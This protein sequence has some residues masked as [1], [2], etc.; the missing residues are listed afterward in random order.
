MHTEPSGSRTAPGGPEPTAEPPTPVGPIHLV[1]DEIA[2]AYPGRPVFAGVTV[3]VSDGA[4]LGVVGENGS[5]KSTLLGVLAGALRPAAGQVRRAGTLA[6]VEQELPVGPKQTVGDLIAASLRGLREVAARLDAAARAFDHDAGNLNELAAL[7]ARAE[8]VAAWDADRRVDVALSRLGACRDAARPL[9]ELSVGERYRVRLACRLAE[10][11]D[12]ILLDEPTNHLDAGGIDFLTTEL[13][14]WRGAVVVVTHD[15]QLLD[16]V[17]TAILDL[18]PGLDGR[19]V[20]YGQ[21]GYLAYRFAKN[22]AMHRWRARYRA[23][24][25]RA[26][27]LAAQLDASYEGLSD[28]WRPLRGSEK[29]RRATRARTHVKA[30]DRAIQRLEAAAVEVPVPPLELRFPDLPAMAPGWDPGRALVEVRNPRVG[31]ADRPWLDLP[32]TRIAVPASGRLLVTGPNGAG[33]STLL[34]ALAGTVALDRGTRSAVDGVRLGLLAQ[35]GSVGPGG[36]GGSP[37][38]DGR[39]QSPERAGPAE[40]PS[41]FDVYAREALDLL[42]AGGLDPDHLVPVATLG[43]LT[44]AD[45]DRPLA[46]LSAGQRRRFEI[47]RTL[48]AAPHLLMLDEPTNHLSIDLMD[49]LTLALRATAA[50]VVVATHDRRMRD[51]LQDWP[52][53]D[54][55]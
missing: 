31:P 36:D 43:L 46:E 26:V 55:G 25:K 14:T 42:A 48:L 10:R 23:E 15:R 4:R 53:L 22:Q 33:K 11:P 50:A 20:L 24:R 54:L 51:E 18:D 3:R 49:E 5:G 1:A 29:H 19:P 12:L 44:E 30:A 7:L 37:G 8:H 34:R 38:T 39:S 47:A 45:L 17:A 32:G 2:F 40:S 9:A 21:P 28:E 13:M 41:G 27:A 35:E 52:G 16:D 6:L